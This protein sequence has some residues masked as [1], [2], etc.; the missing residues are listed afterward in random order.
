MENK[1]IN[2][3]LS[4][5]EQVKSHL[6][7][8]SSSYDKILFRAPKATKAHL[9]VFEQ[10]FGYIG[11]ILDFVSAILPV[12]HKVVNT[13]PEKQDDIPMAAQRLGKVSETTEMATTEI[14][15]TVDRIMTTNGEILKDE[16]CSCGIKDK[17]NESNDHLFTILNAL[18]FQDITSQQIEGIKSVLSEVNNE[19]TALMSDFVDIKVSKIQVKKGAFDSGAEYNREKSKERQGEIDRFFHNK[20]VIIQADTDENTVK[21][22]KPPK[23]Q[24][25][26][27]KS[28]KAEAVSQNDIDSLFQKPANDTEEKPEPEKKSAP[29]EESVN[30]DDV[31]SLF[32]GGNEEPKKE[33]KKEKKSSGSESVNQDDIDALFNN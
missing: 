3:L 23:P 11:R 33:E 24:L 20:D 2:G 21:E 27:S 1:Q 8:F 31:D 7:I 5:L 10:S 19:L 6:Q 9:M 17:L 18:Q 13:F 15:D 30:Q 28:Q 32:N 14:M 29:K 22:E 25:K 16:S 12:L 26:K 4:D